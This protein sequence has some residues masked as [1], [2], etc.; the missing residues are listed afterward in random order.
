[1]PTRTSSSLE[2]LK[3]YTHA[4]IPTIKHQAT[5]TSLQFCNHVTGAY[6]VYLAHMVE[7]AG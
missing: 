4:R 7:T 2:K 1:M 5:V 3:R 6:E